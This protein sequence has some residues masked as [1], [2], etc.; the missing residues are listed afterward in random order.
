MPLVTAASVAAAT[1]LP[2]KDE[3]APEGAV[4]KAAAETFARRAELTAIERLGADRYAEVLGWATSEVPA[5]LQ[6]YKDLQQAASLLALAAAAPTLNLRATEGGGF[7]RST[8][9]DTSRE[10]L[11]SQQ[12]LALFQAELRGQAEA[13]LAHLQA[14][15]LNRRA[16]P[17]PPT[18]VITTQ[19]YWP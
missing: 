3:G 19:P 17:R 12:Q 1:G 6:A 7:I 10:E 18:G 14:P 5:N 13:L 11:M 9:F 4:E 8:G 16:V 2:Q 15:P